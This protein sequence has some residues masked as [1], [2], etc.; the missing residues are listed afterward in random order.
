MDDLSST[1]GHIRDAK[2][3]SFFSLWDATHKESELKGR[4]HQGMEWHTQNNTSDFDVYKMEISNWIPFPRFC[5]K[6]RLSG[7]EIDIPQYQFQT[8]MFLPGSRHQIRFYFS[9]ESLW[10]MRSL[11]P[12]VKNISIQY[13]IHQKKFQFWF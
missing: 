7:R 4:R 2:L 9:L 8:R 10:V 13:L 3:K 11:E 6:E 5:V 12:R 1:S